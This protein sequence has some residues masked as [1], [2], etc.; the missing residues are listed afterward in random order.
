MPIPPQW[1]AGEDQAL[2][3]S[4]KRGGPRRA[5]EG[6]FFPSFSPSTWLGIESLLGNRPGMVGNSHAAVLRGLLK[7][8]QAGRKALLQPSLPCW[9]HPAAL[10]G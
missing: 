7:E 4:R 9:V 6:C 5:L 10:E 1:N 8:E 3:D 2:G